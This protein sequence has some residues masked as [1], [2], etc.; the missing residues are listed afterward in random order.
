M[1]ASK[2]NMVSIIV[3]VFNGSKTI[4]RTV[5]SIKSQTYENWELLIVNDNSS[6]D[7]SNVL[8]ELAKTDKRI[9]VFDLDKNVG[10]ATARNIGIIE[11]SGRYIAYLDADD[12]WDKMKLEKQLSFMNS[13]GYAFTY[14]GYY[15]ADS[16]GKETKEVKVPKI[17]NYKGLL[18][19]TTI[20]TSTVIFDTDKISKNDIKFERIESEDT[21]T[22][23]RILKKNI[24]AYGLCE[25]LS[26]YCRS[27]GTLSS[28]K[29]VAIKRIWNLYRRQ[30]KMDVFKSFYYLCFWAIN[31]VRRRV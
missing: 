11:S 25:P 9:R 15:F 16:N 8:N 20:F 19:N 18:K 21:A 6:D 24:Y 22:W 5:D 4:E 13:N 23:L 1:S 26:Y 29:F 14:T 2:K 28:N 27:N 17:V 31:A 12:L 30:E 3:P 7:T 10:A